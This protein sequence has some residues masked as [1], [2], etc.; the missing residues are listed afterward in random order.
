VY[1]PV[2]NW[3]NVWSNAVISSTGQEVNVSELSD[4]PAVFYRQGS[5]VGQQFKL[6]L[7]NEGIQ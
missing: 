4:R 5:A 6:N 1:L 7:I 2:G 3:V